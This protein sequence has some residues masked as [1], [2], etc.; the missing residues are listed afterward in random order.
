MNAAS[1]GRKSYSLEEVFD[2]YD[3][4][5]SYLLRALSLFQDRIKRRNPTFSRYVPDSI[6]VEFLK[7]IKAPQIQFPRYTGIIAVQLPDQK[8]SPRKKAAL[9]EMALQ[10]YISVVKRNEI[11]TADE[12]AM[13]MK[14]LEK[15]LK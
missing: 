10:K 9:R 7:D 14:V 11:A 6:R 1:N 15:G 8:F 3:E 12:I 5:Q 13:R 4:Y 2:D